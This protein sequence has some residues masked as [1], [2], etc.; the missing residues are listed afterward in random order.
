MRG[1]KSAFSCL[2]RSSLAPARYYC[3]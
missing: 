3:P 2:I 1:E